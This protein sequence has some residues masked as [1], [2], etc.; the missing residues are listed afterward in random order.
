MP[1]IDMTY[2]KRLLSINADTDGDGVGDDITNFNGL[3][4]EDKQ[5]NAN[6]HNNKWR[7]HEDAEVSA[8][9][10]WNTPRSPSDDNVLYKIILG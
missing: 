7:L 6:N 3:Q 10:Y 1:S 2:N 4:F 8:Y 9:L 5:R